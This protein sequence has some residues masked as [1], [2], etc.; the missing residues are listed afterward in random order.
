MAQCLVGVRAQV[1]LQLFYLFNM[2][3]FSVV[4][5]TEVT[6]L[7]TDFLSEET[8]LWIEV[9]LVHPRWRESQ[10]LSLPP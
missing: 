8:D 4:Q 3:V 9:Y 10:E 6:Q 7:V 5:W 1:Y 2:N